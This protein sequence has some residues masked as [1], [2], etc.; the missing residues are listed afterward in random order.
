M[1]IDRR[2]DWRGFAVAA[3]VVA[4]ATAVGWPLY[5]AFGVSDTN[6]LMLYLLGVLWVA[7]R[8]S[9]GAAI[10]ASVLG[11]LA[12]DLVFVPPFYRLD[13][14]DREYLVTFAVMLV[15]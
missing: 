3:G 10:V 13:V 2:Y 15:T 6:V 4:L 9:R 7:T 11:V 8:L 14:H 5:H 1:G 12:F